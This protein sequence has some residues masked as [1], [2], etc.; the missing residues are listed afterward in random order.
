MPWYYVTKNK[1]KNQSGNCVRVLGGAQNEQNIAWNSKIPLKEKRGRTFSIIFETRARNKNVAH[2]FS[3]CVCPE[4]EI[5]TC[6]VDALP[7]KNIYNTLLYSRMYVCMCVREKRDS[8]LQNSSYWGKY[9]K[10]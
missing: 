1:F 4:E 10:V 5:Y 8:G 6:K 9:L 7:L 2:S 3:K